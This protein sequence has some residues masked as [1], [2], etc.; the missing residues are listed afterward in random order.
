MVFSKNLELMEYQENMFPS[1]LAPFLD[2]YIAALEF[3]VT[4]HFRISETLNFEFYY[5][6]SNG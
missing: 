5:L 4:I 2:V 6:I 3:S 1:K